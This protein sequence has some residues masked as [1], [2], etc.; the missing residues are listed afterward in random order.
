MTPQFKIELQ[1]LIDDAT[2]KNLNQWCDYL[3]GFDESGRKDITRED[4]LKGAKLPSDL[5][6]KALENINKVSNNM[7]LDIKM[8]EYETVWSD[9]DNVR[10]T[11]ETTQEVRIKEFTKLKELISE[12]RTALEGA[13]K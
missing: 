11:L 4:F 5:L 9:P 6:V 7:G 10:K 3:W 2:E 12:I 13:A 8:V 1:K